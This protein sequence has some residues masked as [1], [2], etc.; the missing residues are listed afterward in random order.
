MRSSFVIAS[1]A[2]V[3]VACSSAPP[4]E[5]RA[6]TEQT[7]S[8]ESATTE[9]TDRGQSSI[10]QTRFDARLSKFEYPHEVQIFAF[11]DQRQPL[12]MAYMDVPPTGTANGE[13]VLLLH[14]KNFAGAYWKDTIATLAEKGYRVVVPDQIGFGKSTKPAAY[15]FSFHGLA[16]NTHALLEK[17]GVESVSVVGHSMGGMLATRYALM[18][19]ESTEKLVLVNPIGLEDWKLVVPYQGVDAWYQSELQK[20]PEKVRAYMQA[21]Y[22][23]GK[24]KPEYDA[25]A[26]LQMGWADEEG[27]GRELVA[28]SSALTYDMIFTQPVL[29]EFGQLKV[30]TLLIIVPAAGGTV[31]SVSDGFDELRTDLEALSWRDPERNAPPTG[32]DI[33]R[34]MGHGI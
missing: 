20:T 25:V 4:A 31:T 3:T 8:E 23:D 24:W 18:Y 5:D 27:P 14:G 21:S 30:P 9:T 34:D 33:P 32:S 17:I 26:A 12:E 7:P 28:W 13:A 29:Y 15:Q 16:A 11:E 1:I 6:P 22:F 10:E 19:P 2:L